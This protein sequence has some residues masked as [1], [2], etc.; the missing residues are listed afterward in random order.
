MWDCLATPISESLVTSLVSVDLS[1]LTDEYVS[2]LL[3]VVP[4]FSSLTGCGFDLGESPGVLNIALR[5]S[6]SP[7]S[8][9][10][11]LFCPDCVSWM[12]VVG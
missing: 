1:A 12:V 6:S 11:C 10:Q 7:S 2:I 5:I 8:L 4:V 3:S 9:G